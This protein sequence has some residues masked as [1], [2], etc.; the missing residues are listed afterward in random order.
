M[1]QRSHKSS[2]ERK[3]E[4]RLG[5][6]GEE[7]LNESIRKCNRERR[8]NESPL[9]LGC[10]STQKIFTSDTPGPGGAMLPSAWPSTS[11]HHQDQAKA[12]A[13]SFLQL[14]SSPQNMI[15]M[16]KDVSQFS[17][18]EKK[19]FSP[20]CAN[21]AVSKRTASGPVVGWPPIRSFRKNIASGSTSNSKLPSGSQQQHQNV[22]P[23]KVASQKPTDNSGKGLFVKINMDGVAIGRKVDINAYDSYEKLSSA[24]DELFRGL[25]AEMKLSHIASSQCCSGQRDSCAG[26]IQ[27]K[28]Q[29]EKSNTGLLVGSGEYTLVY[30]DNEGD[31][32]LV[33]DVP[34]H[35]F[36]STVKRLRVLKSSDLPAFT[37]GS[38]QD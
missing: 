17:C 25:L 32:M 20:S 31:R 8:R 1:W 33:G 38:K 21:P 6:P 28:E 3:L 4:L 27:N 36:V 23:G 11:Y 37:L 24:V 12:K 34:W 14:Q 22:V 5:P 16:G 10:F 26:G 30:E 29:E 15:L 35:M 9:T 18:V 13:S 19:S 2:E 7:S